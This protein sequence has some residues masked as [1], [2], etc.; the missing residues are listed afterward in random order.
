MTVATRHLT[1]DA[2][3]VG[4]YSD[5]SSSTRSPTTSLTVSPMA[6]RLWSWQP[7]PIATSLKSVWP[8]EVSTA[9]RWESPH[10]FGRY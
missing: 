4:F 5:G 10:G 8:L 6:A 7:Q 3:V 2:D 9:N 1:S